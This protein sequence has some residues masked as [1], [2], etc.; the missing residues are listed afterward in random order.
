MCIF[1]RSLTHSLTHSQAHGKVTIT[2]R[3]IVK[4]SIED[5]YE[6]HLIEVMWIVSSPPLQLF[7]HLFLN[8]TDSWNELSL[9]LVFF[10]V[11]YLKAEGNGIL[12]P[13]DSR[14]PSL[15]VST[16]GQNSLWIRPPEDELKLS[17]VFIFLWFS[18]PAASGCW[19]RILSGRC[20]TDFRLDAENFEFQTGKVKNQQPI[21]LASGISRRAEEWMDQ[22]IRP[23]SG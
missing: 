16:D 14:C 18:S 11:R 7:C 9:M 3:L 23:L 20:W 4:F 17:A 13:V 10:V 8:V 6:K 22:Q 12:H 1:I 5:W 19:W 15:G 2:H 21:N